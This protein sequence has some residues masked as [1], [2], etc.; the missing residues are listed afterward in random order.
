MT[1]PSQPGPDPV[2]T[3][4][5]L[6]RNALGS[7]PAGLLTDLDG[8]LAPMV[9]DPDASRPLPAAVEALTALTQRLAVVAVISGR[10]PDDARLRLG[11]DRLLI[12]G[13]HGLERLE[14]GA[15]R[16]ALSPVLAEAAA[17]IRR[18][19][20]RVPSLAGVWIDDKGPSATIHYRSA[21]DP[22]GAA[23]R[24]AAA[25][26]DVSQD[27]LVLR[28]G[29]MSWELRAAGAADKGSAT[30]QLIAH[31]ALRGLVVLGDDVTDLD[32]FRAASEARARG[33]LSAAILAV[34]GGDEVPPAV[35]AAADAVLPDPQAVAVVLTSLAERP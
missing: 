8:T 11:S 26:G 9:D 10:A 24:I 22:D 15:E 28:A 18:A 16:A 35:A 32:M 17:A 12:I 23:T 6:A 30:A 5:G 13:N 25:L 4:L 3:A 19:L 33:D 29:R 31:H 34:A 14:P 21:P 1:D 27:G 2:A 7:A 20:T